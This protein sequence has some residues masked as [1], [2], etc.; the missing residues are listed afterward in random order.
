MLDLWL[1]SCVLLELCG[2]KDRSIWVSYDDDDGNS[3]VLCSLFFFWY[4]SLSPCCLVNVKF[5]F[6]Q[7]LSW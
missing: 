1:F 5:M 3:I 2:S 6:G 4:V 7:G